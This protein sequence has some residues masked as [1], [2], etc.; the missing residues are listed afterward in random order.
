[1]G[2]SCSL[3]LYLSYAGSREAQIRLLAFTQAGHTSIQAKEAKS[4]RDAN[5]STVSMMGGWAGFIVGASQKKQWL[6]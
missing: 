6:L 3:A 2:I 1:M 4:E 5:W